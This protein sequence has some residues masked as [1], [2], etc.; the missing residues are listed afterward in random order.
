[1]GITGFV[2]VFPALVATQRFT[3]ELDRRDRTD[4]VM[5]TWVC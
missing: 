3:D 2:R 1:M 5:T 4:E